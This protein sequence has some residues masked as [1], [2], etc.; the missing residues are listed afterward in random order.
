MTAEQKERRFRELV[1]ED[2]I[3]IASRFAEDLAQRFLPFNE[4][5]KENRRRSK[6]ALE[7]GGT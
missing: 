3:K 6:Q 5:K 4:F 7:V 2:R 1:K